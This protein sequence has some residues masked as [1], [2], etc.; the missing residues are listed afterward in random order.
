MTPSPKRICIL[1]STGSI[2]E[3]T[4][5]V[6]DDYPDRF[7]VVGL[8]AHG[9][10]A[11]LAQQAAQYGAEQ[12]CISG[13]GPADGFNGH[14]PLRGSQGLIEL[15]EACAPDIVVVATVGYAGLAPTLRAI[16][17]GITVALANKE[18]LVT[19]GEI[20][21]ARARAR[22]VNILPIDSE[23]NAI[24]Q[25]L[26]SRSIHEHC[27]RPL[28]RIILTASG[29]PFR[30]ASR[31]E[32]ATVTREQ[33][34]N[35]P[36]WSMGPKITIDS[37]TLMN[38]GFEVLE[39]HHLFGVGT[40]RIEV[41][42]HPQS[43]VHSMI[44]YHDG[45]MLAQLGV[46]N[47]YLPIA[48]VLAWP[49]RLECRR[50]APLDLAT[51][52][53]LTF[54]APDLGVFPC[55]RYAYDCVEAGATYPTVLNAANEVAVRRFLEGEIGFQEIPALIDAVLQEHVP[56]AHPDL[57]AIAAADGWARQSCATRPAAQS[58]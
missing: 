56:V 54:E 1:G 24:F 45:S 18:V 23:H 58:I 37:A 7:R 39:V 31:E 30:G 57:E 5:R 26:G 29:G 48:N 4:L 44:E 47:M 15:V 28:R 17:L 55:L 3:S 2:G 46:T 52:A 21:M 33:A 11:R 53:S 27:E 20:V 51:L 50:F 25:C 12:V 42:I 13:E 10:C 34:L 38:K 41:V 16:D 32:L 22:G 40:D 9:S 6:I 8:S 43:V 49:E 36:T 35:H 19:A 14:R